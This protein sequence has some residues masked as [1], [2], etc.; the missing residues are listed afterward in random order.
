MHGII[1]ANAWAAAETALLMQHALIQLLPAP[2]VTAGSLIAS[3]GSLHD[4]S[5]T[6]C[7]PCCCRMAGYVNQ[8][9][10]AVVLTFVSGALGAL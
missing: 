10:L 7:P 6:S 8:L 2:P 4:S 9:W 1:W 3:R 5:I